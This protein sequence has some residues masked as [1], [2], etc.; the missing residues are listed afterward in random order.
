MGGRG[1]SWLSWNARASALIVNELER[2][3]PWRTLLLDPVDWGTPG[4]WA[5]IPALTSQD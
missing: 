4:K 1:A 3:F 5:L 2:A